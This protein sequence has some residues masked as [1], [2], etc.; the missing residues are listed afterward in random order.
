[1]YQKLIGN[2]PD[3]TRNP[4]Y[5]AYVDPVNLCDYMLLNFYGGN[6]D[7]DHHNWV[8]GRNR[9]NPQTGFTFFCW[10]SEKILENVN[11]NYVN[12]N[13]ER[14][15]SGIFS[16]LMANSEFRMLF[17]DRVNLH[18]AN[19]GLLTPEN[20]VKRWLKRADQ[21]DT[22]LVAESAR[23]GDYRR[24]VHPWSSA[25]YTLYTVNDHWMAEKKRL[26]DSYF[27]ARTKIVLDQLVSAG[28]IPAVPAPLFSQFGGKVN[29]DF[30]LMITAPT[31][32]IYCTT[33]GSDPRLTGGKVNPSAL[34][35]I[36]PIK[37]GVVTEVKARVKSGEIWSALTAATFYN[38]NYLPGGDEEEKRTGSLT[39]FP[40]PVRESAY[41][42]YSL[43]IRGEVVLTIFR[44]DGRLVMKTQRGFQEA[45]EH[46][47]FWEPQRLNSG[48]YILQLSTDNFRAEQKV[49]LLR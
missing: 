40:N 47:L 46:L 30:R 4:A 5:P 1:V 36:S 15:P 22:A 39:V 35:Y 16:R 24:D 14:M 32:F 18:M 19:H 49:L 42:R 8:A 25:P 23:W 38:E 9:V 34:P 45:G 44:T 37:T 48:L 26:T 27:P 33:D 10:D 12:E 43:P 20:S 28:K 21:I 7:W 31:G 13:N 29:N 3:G 6:N 2:N 11:E 41:I 17:A